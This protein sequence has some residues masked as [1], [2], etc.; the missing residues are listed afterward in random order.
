ML[1]LL[2]ETFEQNLKVEANIFFNNFK[3]MTFQS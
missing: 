2:Q 3:V 1:D